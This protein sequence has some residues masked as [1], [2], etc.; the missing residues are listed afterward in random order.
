MKS[1]SSAFV[2]I[3]FSFSVFAAT[4]SQESVNVARVLINN[5]DIVK[6]LKEN[7][8]SNLVDADMEEV[9]TGIYHYT[10]VFDRQCHCTPS[11]ATVRIL[12]DTT[13][14]FRDGEIEY[15]SSIEIKS[16]L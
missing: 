8:S 15:Y 5:P 10:L 9:T 14:T 4:P 12:E 7:N 13:P 1:I 3:L 16:E 11:I 2:A 6:V